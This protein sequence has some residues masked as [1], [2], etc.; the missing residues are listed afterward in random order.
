MESSAPSVGDTARLG[1][2][3]GRAVSVLTPS[4]LDGLAEVGPKVVGIFEA[5][6]R[7]DGVSI[8]ELGKLY[9]SRPVTRHLVGLAS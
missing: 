3:A 6:G 7:E 4:L 1:A 8:V 5:D 9:V 2:E